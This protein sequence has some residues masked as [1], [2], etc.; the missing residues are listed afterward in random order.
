M[1][2]LEEINENV[3]GYGNCNFKTGY[4][5]VLIYPFVHNFMKIKRKK[6]WFKSPIFILN[7]DFNQWFKAMWFKG[8]RMGSLL[9]LVFPCFRENVV[10]KS[11]KNSFSTYFTHIHSC[12]LLT[13]LT[14]FCMLGWQY[15]NTPNLSFMADDPIA[16]GSIGVW[17]LLSIS[18]TIAQICSVYNCAI[19]LLF[20]F[21][22][23]TSRIFPKNQFCT[24]Y[25]LSRATATVYSQEC[26][27][28][29]H[30]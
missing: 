23:K 26:L 5:K 1:F 13:L 29:S 3:S 6:K 22:N 10:G 12:I 19:L 18:A 24:W 9:V 2:R 14:F 20:S 8:W 7:P 21:Q 4:K 17:D 25:Y 11:Y 16:W 30:V 27:C 28:H 15:L